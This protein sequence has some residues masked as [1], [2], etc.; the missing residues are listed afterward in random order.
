MSGD[1]RHLSELLNEGLIARV[2]REA[3]RRRKETVAILAQLPEEEAA[4]VLSATRNETGELVLVVD[5]PAWAARLRYS[6]AG[7]PFVRVRV[8]V[9][10]GGA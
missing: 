3:D 8:R 5:S 2:V 9:G 4:H 10:P 1:P 7:L 6:A